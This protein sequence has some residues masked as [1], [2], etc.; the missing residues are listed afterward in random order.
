M[1]AE[2]APP[3]GARESTPV[4]LAAEVARKRLGDLGGTV[5]F[6]KIMT[7]SDTSGSGRIVIPKVRV[8]VWVGVAGRVG[9]C[10]AAL[11]TATQSLGSRRRSLRLVIIKP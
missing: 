2:E 7:T 8:W 3:G 4:P 6:E 11:F 1:A 10:G 5:L 9:V